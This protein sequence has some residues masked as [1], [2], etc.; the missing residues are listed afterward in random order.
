MSNSLAIATVTA[1]L[2]RSLQQALNSATIGAVA[3]AEVK[4]SRPGG[5]GAATKGINLYLYQVAPNPALRNADL[6]L[7]TSGGALLQKPLAALDLHY[8]LSFYGEEAQLE[9]QRMLG[10]VEAALHARPILTREAIRQ[11]IA[12]VT[13]NPILVGS[14]LADSVELVRFTPLVLTLEEMSKIW[15]VF[16]QTAHALSVAYQASV[17]LIETEDQ[18]RVQIPVRERRFYSFARETPM[19]SRAEPS[20]ARVGGTVV[21]HGVALDGDTVEV[22]IDGGA[23]IPATSVS[24]SQVAFVVPGALRAGAHSV[25]VSHLRTLSGGPAPD[26]AFR[27]DTNG[28]PFLLVPSITTPAPITGTPGGTLTLGVSPAVGRD[29][30]VRL[31]VGDRLVDGPPH[32]PPPPDADV[33]ITFTLPGD[34][35][36]GVQALR[37]EVGGAMSL[38]EADPAPPGYVPTIEVS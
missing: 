20:T 5:P 9:P 18:P 7:R 14:D 24:A 11:T 13:F 3:G 37:I 33:S 23:P 25:C 22:R 17:V 12:D 6:P 8:M 31:V 27:V 29:Q 36:L 32:L 19:L 21:L 38:L 30:P 35:A 10:I 4:T 26:R 34:L 16:F 2:E 15:S 1:T 28:V